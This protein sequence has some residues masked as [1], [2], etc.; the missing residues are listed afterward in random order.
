M[1]ILFGIWNCAFQSPKPA[2]F[3][4]LA[5]TFAGL[6]WL[7]YVRCQKR[8]EDFAKAIYDLFISEAAKAASDASKT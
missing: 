7:A 4:L 8:G 2:T 5:A 3:L 1:S 6:T